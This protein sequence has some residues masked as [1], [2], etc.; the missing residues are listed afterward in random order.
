MRR[1]TQSNMK[2]EQNTTIITPSA[3]TAP[4]ATK[5]PSATAPL[6]KARAGAP[7]PTPLR[8]SSASNASAPKAPR[9][10]DEMLEEV[11]DETVDTAEIAEEIPFEEPEI[12]PDPPKRP[13]I[14]QRRRQQL[15][16][17]EEQRMSAMEI[18]QKR[19]GLSEDDIALIV[20]LGYENELGRLATKP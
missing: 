18:I 3:P 20:E 13:S 8:K 2:K 11:L 1:T 4:P 14:F 10:E 9:V 7:S 6:R 12:V 17:L 15:Q 16:Q 5:R 19:S